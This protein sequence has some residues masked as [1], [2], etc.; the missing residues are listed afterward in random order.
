MSVLQILPLV[1]M[2]LSFIVPLLFFIHTRQHGWK[3]TGVVF[4]CCL[5]IVLL[6]P[7]ISYV[8]TEETYTIVYFIGKLV[9]FTFFPLIVLAYVE[10]NNLLIFIQKSGVRKKHLGM[11]LVLGLI[12]LCI[13]LLIGMFI[14]G[15]SSANTDPV[16][17]VIMFFEAFNE[18]FLF[19]GVFFLYL[20][21]LTNTPVAFT[22]SVLAFTLAHP[23]HFTSLFLISTLMQ[24]I[25]LGLV[26]VKT[27][28]I[29]GPWISHGLNRT[30]IQVLRVLF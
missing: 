10:K 29:I 19:R 30:I 7:L 13:T 22:T 24:G 16:W 8:S 3:K 28:N 27:E 14:S 12:A 23:Q 20:S 26:T 25:L 21:K 15:Q 5:A 4:L 2:L 17:N 18:E 1:P 6:Y 9:L 11:S